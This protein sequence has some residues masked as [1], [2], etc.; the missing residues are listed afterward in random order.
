MPL[1]KERI[2]HSATIQGLSYGE[3]IQLGETQVSLHSA[4]HILGSSQVR[5]EHRGEVWV[6]TGDYKRD[7]DPT[8]PP[9]E[10]IP[11]DVLVTEA[12]FGLPVYRWKEVSEVALEMV[13]WWRTLAASG[14]NCVLFGYSLGKAQRVLAEMLPYLQE[15]EKILV[16]DSM[17]PMNRIYRE[18]GIA[19]A[20]TYTFSEVA[21]GTELRGVFA[22]LP[23][24]AASNPILRKLHPCETGFASGWMR[25]QNKRQMRRFDRSFV[26]SD[27]ADWPS[28]LQTVQQTQAKKVYVMHGENEILARYLT[29]QGTAA[30]P[31]S[32]LPR[33]SP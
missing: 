21:T 18:A 19:L 20:P 26:M 4:G 32:A 8:C 7:R 3:V 16:H 1:L 25:I 13:E 9:F 15:G 10:V 30:F 12:T 24:G 28:L 2:G 14:R 23:P 22:I 5:I 27:H 11:C 29:E 6:I 31:I 33:L 17:E